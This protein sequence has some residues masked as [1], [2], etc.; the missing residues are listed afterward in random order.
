MPSNLLKYFLSE[1][2]RSW[3]GKNNSLT[4]LG[5]LKDDANLK[6]TIMYKRRAFTLI[7]LLVVI[8]IIALLMGIM[9]PILQRVREQGKREIDTNNIEPMM[10]ARSIYPYS[11]QTFKDTMYGSSRSSLYAAMA[12]AVFL[13]SAV[14][15]LALIGFV[16]VMRYVDPKSTILVHFRRKLLVV[17]LAGAAA[18]YVV[19]I[20]L[21]TWVMLQFV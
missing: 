11:E 18:L 17:C 5:S 1:Q 10:L 12:R 8:A 2:N 9:M 16:V 4:P 6:G 19:L 20:V 3:C 14:V 7:E 13:S 21:M 15:G